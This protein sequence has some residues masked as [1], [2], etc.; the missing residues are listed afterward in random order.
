MT[1][2]AKAKSNEKQALLDEVRD[3]CIFVGRGTLGREWV[4]CALDALHREKL[5][6]LTM[7]ELYMLDWLLTVVM[8]YKESIDDAVADARLATIDA[9]KGGRA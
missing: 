7:G 2:R 5:T 8:L 9:K 1:A 4:Y 6:D 3:K